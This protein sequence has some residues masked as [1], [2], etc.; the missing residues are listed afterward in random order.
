[1]CKEH[2]HEHESHHDCKCKRCCEKGDRGPQGVAGEQGLQGIQGV[3]GLTGAQ[4]IQ[5]LQ[6]IQGPKGDQG[7]Q[8]EKGDCVECRCECKSGLPEFAEVFSSVSQTLSASPGVNL[9]GTAITWENTIVATAN[10]DVSMA[11]A[12]G[13]VT[14]KTSGWYEL[15]YGAAGYLNPVPSPLPV[16]SVSI[17][18]N[19]VYVPGSTV[20]ALPISPEQQ[21]TQV[22]A[23]LLIHLDAGDTI[24]LANTSTATLFLNAPSL[25]TNSTPNSSFLVVKL[26]KAD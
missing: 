14:A 12:N 10:I 16:W 8:G 15:T 2:G 24:Y 19:T 23:D 6:G 13:D 18:K 20:C 5:G 17:F 25:G 21:A 22:V 3:P 26:L 7:I 1:M 11:A 4:G 9:S